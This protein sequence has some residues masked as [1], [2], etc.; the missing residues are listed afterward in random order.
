MVGTHKEDLDGIK[1][2]I[3]AWKNI[4]KVPFARRHIEGKFN[5]ILDTLFEILSLSKKDTEM[6]RFS[7]RLDQLS[8]GN[9]T[10]KIDG[11]KIFLM[12]KVDE[13]Q[14]EIFQLENNI[15]FFAKAKKDSPMVLEVKKNIDKQ[16]EELA[17]WKEKLKQIRNL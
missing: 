4:G 5:K 10:K 9:D 8:E 2:H 17:T 1:A 11:E 6:M 13:V 14:N 3:E 15:Q 7:N 12:R 16:K